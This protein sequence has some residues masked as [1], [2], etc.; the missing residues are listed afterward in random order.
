LGEEIGSL[1][2]LERK[3]RIYGALDS[4]TGAMMGRRYGR[5]GLMLRRVDDEWSRWT[6]TV[7][8]ICPVVQVAR[9][10][11]TIGLSF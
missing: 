11:Y 8:L 6:A 7:I 5:G 1:Q 4:A 3:S 9:R 2:V 10:V